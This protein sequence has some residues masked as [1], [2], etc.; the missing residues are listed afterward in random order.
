MTVNR[1]VLLGLALATAAGVALASVGRHCTR[2]GCLPGIPARD[3][4][5]RPRSRSV[6]ALSMTSVPLQEV[7][8]QAGEVRGR[9]H[10]YQWDESDLKVDHCSISGVVLQFYKDG[11]W[12]LSLRG[13]QNPASEAALG[14][15]AAESG[16]YTAHLKRNEFVVQFR[17]YGLYQVGVSSA[18]RSVGKPVL[19]PLGPLKFWVQRGE[20]REYVFMGCDDEVR[21]FFDRIDR[22][23]LEFYYYHHPGAVGHR[24]STAIEP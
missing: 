11:R 16:R 15:A 22:V 2:P 14:P 4:Q 13:H 20:P 10:V 12:T 18:A 21:E 8:T 5:Y 19:F 1:L 6:V 23:E 24:M 7:D 3:Y 17:C 9:I